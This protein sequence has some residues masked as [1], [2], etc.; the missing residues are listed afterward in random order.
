MPLSDGCGL[1]TSTASG[2]R[3]EEH[4]PSSARVNT[5]DGD[6][7]RK[8]RTVIRERQADLLSKAISRIPS[9]PELLPPGAQCILAASKLMCFVDESHAVIPTGVTGM[10]PKRQDFLIVDKDR[11]STLGLVIY[12]LIVSANQNEEL[13]VLAKAL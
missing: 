9:D 5:S 3:K 10:S 11:S 2:K 13:T 4:T 6:D 8:N 1:K 12:P 7:T